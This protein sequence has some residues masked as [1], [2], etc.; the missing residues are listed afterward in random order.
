MNIDFYK[1]DEA[2]IKVFSTPEIEQEIKEY[3]T[4]KAPGYA[5]HPRFRARMWDGNVSLYDLRTKT[6]AIGLYKR[7]CEFATD[8]NITLT[9]RSNEKYSEFDTHDVVPKEE[10]EAF[11]NDLNL[12]SKSGP[13]TFRDYQFD[14]SYKAIT[15]KKI[16]MTSPTA[17][18][19]SAIIYVCIRWILEQD[20]DSRVILIVPNV[21]L[22]NQMMADFKEYSMQNGFDVDRVCQ[23]LYGGQSKDLIKRCLITTWQSFTKLTKSKDALNFMKLYRGVIVDECHQSAAKELQSI[24]SRCT[25]AQYR[26]GTSGTVDQSSA[27]KVNLLQIEGYLGPVHKVITTKQL[28]DAGQVSQLKIKALVLK[29]L[30]DDCK[31]MKKIEYADEI[32]WLVSHTARNEFLCKVALA[33]QQSNGGATLLLVRNRET[34]AKPLYE[35]IKAMANCPVYYISGEV[36]G[37]QREII[38]NLANVGTCIIVA[39]LATMAVGVNIPNIRS[40]I[41]G[42]PSKSMI[43]VLQS[44]GRALRLHSEKD[45]AIVYD[46]IDDLRYK[47]RDNYV[48]T[49]GVERLTIYRKE[50]FDINVKEIALQ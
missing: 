4:F 7:L 24:L 25:N 2:H 42:S 43:T 18:G 36:S 45:C 38:R 37:E 22:V 46:I 33:A 32:A 50:R 1:I 9:F 13:I 12:W 16:T 28:M 23:R 10:F 27:A 3:F 19:K 11:V 8:N 34:H 14:A 17:S 20:P 6:L 31:A 44:I 35:K 29:H 21:Q 26:I 49:H 30:P 40:I 15:E 48:Y 47:K 41:F 5:F 39:T